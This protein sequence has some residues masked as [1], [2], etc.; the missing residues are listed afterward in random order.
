[1]TGPSRESAPRASP[2]PTL[3]RELR[4]DFALVIPAYNEAE[5]VPDLIRELRETFRRHHLNGEV[6]VV[7]DGSTDGTAERVEAEG[8]GWEPLRVLRHRTNLGKTE[9][10]VTAAQATRRSWIV[11]FDA[12]LQHSPEE[13]P[14]F[15]ALLEEGWDIVTGRKVGPYGKQAISST[16]NR[17]SRAI[18]RVPV[19][20]LNSMKAFRRS[21]LVEMNLRH[22]WHR[23]FVVLAHARGYSVTELDITLYP[24]RAG[25]SKYTG[26]WRVVVGLMDLVS[27]WFLLLFSRK[28]LLLFGF[29]GLV[30]IALGV[31]VGVVALY[32]RFVMGQGFRPLLTLVVLLET[33]GVVLFGFGLL[34]EMVA[35]LRAEVDGIRRRREEP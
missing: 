2:P 4:S 28:P 8:E 13:I 9:A 16:Y 26:G 30:L 23:F 32:F 21:I 20:D 35:Q 17:L 1:V 5:M 3:S 10:M 18:F 6:L 12:D 33:V 14:R 24:R 34:A 19:S 11:L 31:A 29:T 22:D 7:D 27:V 15:L 25:I